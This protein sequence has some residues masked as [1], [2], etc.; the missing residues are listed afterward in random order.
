VLGKSFSSWPKYNSEEVQ[1]VQ[2][3]LRSN[4]E[5]YWTGEVMR[6]FEQDF[7]K[8]AGT[9]FAVALANGTLALDV[10][11]KAPK[12][13]PG[14]EVNTTRSTFLASAIVTAGA[15]PDFADVDA[16]TQNIKARTIEAVVTKRARA[17]FCVHLRDIP[18]DR[19]RSWNWR[20]N[21]ASM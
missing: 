12:I 6:H 19:T 1:S 17:I 15:V 4:R 21:M 13:G 14:D 2:E 10:A 11:L 8:W 5:N 18:C 20:L 9:K 7:P 3:V 16:D